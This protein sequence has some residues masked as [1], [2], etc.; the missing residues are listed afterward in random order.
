MDDRLSDNSP[1][2][3]IAIVLC[4]IGALLFWGLGS[5]AWNYEGTPDC[6]A[7]DASFAPHSACGIADDSYE[8]VWDGES[9]SSRCAGFCEGSDCRRTFDDQES[10]EE[11]YA[12]CMAQ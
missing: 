6:E 3:A 5:L 4:I 1:N 2:T 7:Q 12:H 8:Y 10:C 11:T 9:C